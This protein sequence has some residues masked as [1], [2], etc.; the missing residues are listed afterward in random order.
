M[1]ANRFPATPLE[2][3]KSFIRHRS[4]IWQMTKREVI[5]RYRGSVMGIL[6][7]FLN[8]LLMLTVYTF[9]FSTVFKA[10]W[11][12]GSESQTDFAIVLFSGMI[13]YGIFAECINRAPSLVLSNVSYVKKVVFPLEILTWTA[14]GSALFHSLVSL[15]VLVCAML[16]FERAL[17]WTVLLFPL[18]LLPLVM[19]TLGL[20][21]FISA[22]GVYVRD[23]A[24][25]TGIFTTV[26]MF[27]SPVFYPLSALPEKY[28]RILMLNPL[29]FVIEQGR[30]VLIWGK[31]LDF[32][33]WGLHCAASL[34]VAWAG[35]W[36]FQRTRKGFADVL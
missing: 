29:A 2:M 24:Q 33:G 4:L 15:V 16:I 1:A 30:Q 25:T 28:Q 13:V 23:I 36:W 10:R 32:E 19:I 17:N 5:G 3:V 31:L 27:L 20:A 7:S 11:G 22:A 12:S 21:W 34:V 18:V 26:L 6:W 8:P 35:F 9:V 14:L